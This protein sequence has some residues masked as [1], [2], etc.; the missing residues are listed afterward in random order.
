MACTTSGVEGT[1]GLAN[2]TCYFQ[3]SNP[4]FKTQEMI[5]VYK[6]WHK[7]WETKWSAPYNSRSFEPFIGKQCR[8][9]DAHI[10]AFECH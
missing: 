7:Q 1:K 9:G 6:T 2:L 10:L 3:G 8:L 4:Y 5:K